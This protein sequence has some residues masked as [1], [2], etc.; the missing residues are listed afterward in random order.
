VFSPPPRVVRNSLQSQRWG[1]E[2]SHG[3]FPFYAGQG[4]EIMVLIEPD[5]FKIAINGQH[6]T[7]FRYRIPLN[8]VNY[9]SIDGDV[10]ISLIKFEAS[11]QPSYGIPSAPPMT[12]P[13]SS[14][15]APYPAGSAPYPAGSAPY[16]AGSAQY[17][18]MPGVYAPPAQSYPSQGYPTQAPVYPSQSAYPAP[19][20]PAPGYP[21]TAYPVSSTDFRLFDVP[22]DFLMITHPST[23]FAAIAK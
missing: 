20:Y 4:F 2:E 12:A 18:S 7:E 11:T 3:G 15:G 10:T 21:A 6:F 9:I 19:G 1:P 5:H 22:N 8:R 14:S 17:P 23:A 13:Y 16:P